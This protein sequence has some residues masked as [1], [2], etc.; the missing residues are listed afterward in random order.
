MQARSDGKYEICRANCLLI[1]HSRYAEIETRIYAYNILSTQ[2][3]CVRQAD[4]FLDNSAALVNGGNLCDVAKKERLLGVIALLRES[5]KK[6]AGKAPQTTAEEAA[7][8]NQ[9]SDTWY[10]RGSPK[11]Q[12]SVVDEAVKNENGC[13]NLS[14]PDPATMDERSIT[15]RAEK[16]FKWA[17]EG[18]KAKSNK[19]RTTEEILCSCGRQGRGQ[20]CLVHRL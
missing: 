14:L 13:T 2:A 5:A 7:T 9:L 8:E 3:S 6:R 1:V 18:G 15:P 12:R 19:I 16:I 20:I 4:R 17:G 10:H 11:W